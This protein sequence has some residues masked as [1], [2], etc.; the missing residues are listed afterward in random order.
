MRFEKTMEKRLSVE[1]ME[2]VFELGMGSIIHW[3]VAVE[4]DG[5]DEYVA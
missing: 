3:K 1:E 2:Y 5:E 4:A